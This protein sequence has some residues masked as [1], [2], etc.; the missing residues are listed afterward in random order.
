MTMMVCQEVSLV[1]N[2]EAASKLETGGGPNIAKAN[3]QLWGQA[4]HCRD[5]QYPGLFL[6]GLSVKI[7]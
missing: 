7:I 3:H 5:I 6:E 4:A 1:M 2:M